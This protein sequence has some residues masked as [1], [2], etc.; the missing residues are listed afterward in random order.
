M[1]GPG[2]FDKSGAD[3]GLIGMG[4]KETRVTRKGVWKR[5]SLLVEGFPLLLPPWSTAEMQALPTPSSLHRRVQSC[6]NF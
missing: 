1:E 5:T 6:S 2:N 3:E 4:L